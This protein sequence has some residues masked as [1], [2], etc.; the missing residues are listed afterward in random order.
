[1]NDVIR[2]QLRQY[3]HARTEA[4]AQVLSITGKYFAPVEPLHDSSL[5][6]TVHLRDEL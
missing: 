6:H 2:L 1:M 4:I 3:V 5:A